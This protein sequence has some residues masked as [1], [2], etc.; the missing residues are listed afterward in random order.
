[1]F[2]DEL[3]RLRPSKNP[4]AIQVASQEDRESWPVSSQ[5]KVGGATW[6]VGMPGP[7]SSLA[8]FFGVQPPHCQSY[9]IVNG[10]CLP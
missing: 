1:M 2:D 5:L 4:D 9:G 8:F 3:F 10:A 7:P 6:Q